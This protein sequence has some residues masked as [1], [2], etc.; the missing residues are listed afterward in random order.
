M[1]IEKG[2]N[3]RSLSPLPGDSQ[4]TMRSIVR[5][6][7]LIALVSIWSPAPAQ[8][9]II[10]DFEA[11]FPSNPELNMLFNEPSLTLSGITVEGITNSTPG[12]VFYF[13]GLETLAADGGQAR[14][15]AA[16]GAFTSLLIAPETA[17]IWFSKFEANLGV[18]KP[19]HGHASGTVTVTAYDQFGNPTVGQHTIGSNGSNFF[20]VF[21]SGDDLLSAILIESTVSLAEAR[22]VR[23]GDVTFDS[24]DTGEAEAP[25]P[26]ELLLFGAGLLA[27]G[28]RLRRRVRTDVKVG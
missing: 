8:G 12:T 28:R 26:A 21:A 3:G 22:Q 14:V 25:E 4:H 18:L 19:A 27:I 23:V 24:P 10:I 2:E 5:A 9:A 16:D 7:S 1:P 6:L 17:G 13:T 15:E 20:N 11:P